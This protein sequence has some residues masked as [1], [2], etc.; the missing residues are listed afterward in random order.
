MR[1]ISAFA[2][3][4]VAA[5]I[6]TAAS[7]TVIVPVPG[8]F[9]SGVSN[10][11]V[12]LGDNATD[13][14]WRLIA[15]PAGVTLGNTYTG[16]KNASFPIGPWMANTATS[17]WITPT[18]SH[19]NIAAGDYSYELQFTLTP[20]MIT[21]TGKFTGRFAVDNSMVSILLNSTAI[22]A[23]AGSFTAWTNFASNG[24]FVAGLN[25]LTFKTRNAAGSGNNPTGFRVEFLT[26]SIEVLPEPGSWAMMIAGF[27]LIGMSLRQRRSPITA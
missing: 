11:N 5:T 9:N 7:A 17:R 21:S 25:K 26:N 24:G 14:H 6:A 1:F 4:A 10:S 20:K 19:T 15:A 2:S 13:P 22:T 16:V 18:I 12:T 23:T 3:L 27:G 8:L